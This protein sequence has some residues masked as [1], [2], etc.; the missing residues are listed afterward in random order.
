M[1]IRAFAAAMR[2]ITIEQRP[3][4]ASEANIDLSTTITIINAAMNLEYLSITHFSYSQ[5]NTTFPPTAVF[6]RLKELRLSTP[7]VDLMELV[8]FIN[9]Q[10]HLA[11]L[12]IDTVVREKVDHTYNHF[13]CE[14]MAGKLQRLCGGVTVEAS[15]SMRQRE[16][17]K[18]YKVAISDTSA[19][20]GEGADRGADENSE[21]EDR[22]EDEI[23]IAGLDIP[24]YTPVCY[25][26]LP[27][28]RGIDILTEIVEDSSASGHSEQGFMG[29]DLMAFDSERVDPTYT[30]GEEVPTC[31][32]K[33]SY[34]DD[35]EASSAAAC[36]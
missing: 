33:V 20:E 4:L 36:Q 12:D 2:E 19:Q 18:V 26:H 5:E 30:Q 22:D 8:A 9:G 16:T 25:Q 31:K 32:S 15:L 34:Q 14:T 3:G 21:E 28:E 35:Y 24:E 27:T 29:D 1:A 7:F 6:S 13:D 10:P 11:V 23:L 17:Q